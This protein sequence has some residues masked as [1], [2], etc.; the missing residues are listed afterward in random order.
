MEIAL[1]FYH[2]VCLSHLM[3]VNSAVDWVSSFMNDHSR[4]WSWHQ[5]DEYPLYLCD[6]VYYDFLDYIHVRRM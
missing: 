5:D 2:D 1:F 6:I 3:K 4:N